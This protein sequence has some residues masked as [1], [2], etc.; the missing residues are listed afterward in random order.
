MIGVVDW[1]SR[2]TGRV[3]A[4]ASRARQFERRGDRR[5]SVLAAGE[6]CHRVLKRKAAISRR[7]GKRCSSGRRTRPPLRPTIRSLPTRS[8]WERS[9]S[10]DARLSGNG[11]RSCASCHR[12]E[13][14]FTDGR[15]RALAL[16]GAPLRRNTPSLWNLAWSKQFFWDGRAPSLE[17]QVGMPIEEA[18]EMGGDWPQI[19]RRLGEDADLARQFRRRLPGGAQRFAG[20][21]PQGARRVCALARLAADP[22]RCLDR[23]RRAGAEARRGARLPPVHRQGGM[24]PVPRRLALHRRSLSRHRLAGSDGGRG[25]VPGGTPGLRAFKTPSLREVAHTAPYMHDG[26]LAT[27]EAVIGHYAG[28]FVRRPSLATNI[29]RDLR[30]SAQEKAD[31]IAFLRTLSSEKGPARAQRAGP[32]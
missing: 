18:Q 4:H 29:N 1:S 30:L 22:V 25:A 28:G 7:F 31:L 15:R 21:R 5:A 14:A 9:S 11:K 17:A 19:L 20:H 27:L 24:R 26:S 13:R 32:H 2:V 3:T 12:P 10:A 16:S 6:A 23:G 8:R